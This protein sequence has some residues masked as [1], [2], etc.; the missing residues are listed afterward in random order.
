M[1]AFAR[2]SLRSQEQEDPYGAL[3]CMDGSDDDDVVY[4][5]A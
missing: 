3:D 1:T 2:M 4:R 5:R